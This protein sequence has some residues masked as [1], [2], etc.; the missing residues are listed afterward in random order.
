MNAIQAY[1]E[2]ERHCRKCPYQRFINP[3]RCG[4]IFTTPDTYNLPLTEA[5]TKCGIV[6]LRNTVSKKISKK[7]LE[8]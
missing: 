7:I 2:V 3:I 4:R 6:K 8:T 5:V 1:F